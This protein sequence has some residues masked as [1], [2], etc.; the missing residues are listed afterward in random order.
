MKQLFIPIACAFAGITLIVACKNNTEV[1]KEI[2]VF[3]ADSAKATIAAN[4]KAYSEAIAKGDSTSFVNLYTDDL[5][6]YAPNTP[7]ICGKA[8]VGKFF[9]MIQQMGV[10]GLVLKTT[11]VFGNKDVITEIGTYDM[12]IVGGKSVDKGKYVVVWKQVDGKLKM[13]RD[14]FNSNVPL[15]VIAPLA[16]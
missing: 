16:K 15:P 4:N 10:K 9:G 14:I 8:G 5:C 7:E 3:N 6:L 1:V 2:A 11:E 13:H 12:Q